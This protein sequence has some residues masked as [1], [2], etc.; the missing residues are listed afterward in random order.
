MKRDY[1]LIR[2]LLLEV[3]GDSDVDL[4]GFTE[5]QVK[6]HRELLIEAGL[7]EG[8]IKRS[9]RSYTEIPDLALI[10]KLT[11]EGHEFLDQ[12]RKATVWN[13]AKEHLGKKGLELTFDGLKAAMRTIISGLI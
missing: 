12:A 2:Q 7:A 13:R 4:S 1:D 5:D 3:A 6:Y 11:W 10:N 9:S 8:T